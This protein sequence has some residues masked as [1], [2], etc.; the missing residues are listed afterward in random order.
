MG[1]TP[2]HLVVSGRSGVRSVPELRGL[3][4][5]VGRPGSGTALTARLVMKAYG[6]GPDSVRTEALAYN[7]AA[8]RLAAGSLD[9]L[10]IEGSSPLDSITRS[11]RAGA[12]LLSL[13]GP[14]VERLAREYP[15]MSTAVIQGGTY[16]SHPV[17]VQTIGV[18]NL[19]VCSR[20]LEERVVYELV[21]RFHEALPAL[22]AGH[23]VLR[24]M[25][26]EQAPATP[27]RLHD[28]AAR[29]YRERELSQ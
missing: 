16:A 3:R 9:A 28:G 8:D 25:D 18:D 22:A 5:G 29:Y 12:R 6:L 7:E 21:R 2:L 14:V 11:T 17:A 23:R 10:F 15:F 4:V 13:R 24:F 1:L 20:D 26:M 19:L 27:I